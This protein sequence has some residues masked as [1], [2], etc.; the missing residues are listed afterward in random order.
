M[1]HYFKFNVGAKAIHT[2]LQRG[3]YRNIMFYI[4]LA[5]I[6]RGFYNKQVI[7]L[8]LARYFDTQ[9]MPQLFFDEARFFYDKLLAQFKQFN[10]KF[11]TFYDSG[12]CIQ[13]KTIYKQYKGDRSRVIDAIVLE[14]TEKEL[15]KRIKNYYFEDFIPRFTISGLSSVVYM[16]QYESDMLPYFMIQNNLA[17]AGEQTT[18]NVI[19]ST[20]KDLLQT[21]QFYNTIQC[22][23]VY[24]K[25][26]G[27]M[28]FHTLWDANAISYI[29]KKFKRGIL[30]SKHIPLL[31]ALAGDKADNISG[32]P[33]VGDATAC[34]MIEAHSM[35]PV[36][37]ETSYLPP[38]YEKYRSMIIKNY[39]LISFEEQFKRIEYTY[40]NDLKQKLAVI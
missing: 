6:A 2:I 11:I 8:E 19:L 22:S 27:K 34:K 26:I 24:K 13:N 30:T 9:Q 16:D 35:D 5:S 1:Q 38:K 12:E 29:Y 15:F 28:E 33:R 37:T 25:S 39:K 17:G 40:L 18:L 14:D 36:F 32:I 7:S 31:L 21:C 3:Q 10:P 23:T 4:D 20:D